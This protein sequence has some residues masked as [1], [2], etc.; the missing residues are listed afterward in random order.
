MQ[1]FNK[2]KN[3]FLTTIGAIRPQTTVK[4]TNK[5]EGEILCKLY[6]YAL[7]QVGSIEE[8]KTEEK[9]D[10]IIPITPVVT[11][12]VTPVVIAPVSPVVTPVV[13]P[14]VI[15]VITPEA[16]PIVSQSEVEVLSSTSTKKVK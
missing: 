16:L 12:P 11:P 14:E 1:V 9:T 6:N 3:T 8:E 15:P 2:S 5:K 10:V 7:I 4:F 13:T